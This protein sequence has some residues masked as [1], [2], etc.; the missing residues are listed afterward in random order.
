MISNGAAG[1]DLRESAMMTNYRAFR[2]TV[3]EGALLPQS[4]PMFDDLTEREVRA[5]FEFIRQQIRLAD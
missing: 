2:A 4:M 5:L 3:V 1:P